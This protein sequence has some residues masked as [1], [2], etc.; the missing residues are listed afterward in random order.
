MR[1]VLSGL[2]A[3]TGNLFLRFREEVQEE[4]AVIW[5]FLDKGAGMSEK[6]CA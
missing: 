1:F 5:L 6:F 4:S 3:P 2:A